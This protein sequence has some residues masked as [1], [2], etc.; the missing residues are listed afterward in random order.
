[1]ATSADFVREAS[2]ASRPLADNIIDALREAV[3]IVDVNDPKFPVVL[4]NS[5]A[6]R[7]FADGRS[8]R[9]LVQCP[10]HAL[11]GPATDSVVASGAAT[12][13]QGVSSITRVLPWR[14]P[15]GEVLL[16]TEVKMLELSPEHP[17]IMLKF[18]TRAMVS[19]S[20][21][22]PL[23]SIEYLSRDLLILDRELTITYASAGACRSAGCDSDAL[24]N[25]SALIVLPTSAIPREALTG[26]LQGKHFHDN[27]IVVLIPGSVT[28]W[29]DVDVQPIFDQSSVVGI[30]VLSLEIT[31]RRQHRRP[32]AGGD[33]RLFAL[34]EFAPEVIT[35][36]GRDG[37]LLMVSSGV[38]ESLGYAPHE[39]LSHSLL[40]HIHPEDVAAF[41]SEY[42]ALE[43]DKAAGFTRQL[44]L[45]HENGTYRWVDLICA[46]AFDNPFLRGALISVRDLTDRKLAEARVR[47]GDDVFKLAAE[48][49]NG[50]IFEWD[51]ARGGVRRFRGVDDSSGTDLGGLDSRDAWM[52]RIH[53]ED[54]AAYESKMMSAMTSGRGWTASYRIRN[55]RG[56]YRSILERGL[57]QR[58]S[59][60]D[61]IRAIGCAVDVSDISRLTVLLAE[62][63]RIAKMG[64]W[65][66]NFTSGEFEWTEEL[67]RIYEADP[68]SFAATRESMLERCT[69]ESRT[70]VKQ[71]YISA[72]RG[73]GKVDVE[74]EIIT[75]KER[76]IWVRLVAHIEKLDGRPIRAYG[77][78]QDI[79][80]QKQAQIAL[81]NRTDWLKMSM[82]MAQ[83][84][85]W[86]WDRKEDTLEFAIVDGRFVPE[87]LVVSGM[88]HLMA[89]LHSKDR[90]AVRRA[91][92][93]AF[94]KRQEVQ[95]EFR[96]K[97]RGGRHRSYVAIARPLFD[98]ANR[99][100]GLMGVTQ[101]V[102]DRRDS[103]AR[104]RRSEEL[105]R[106]TTSNIADTLI[107][108]DSALRICFINRGI[109]NI[110]VE[111]AVGQAY[112]SVLPENARTAVLDKLNRVWLTGEPETYEFEVSGPGDEIAYF[113]NRAV[114]VR[115]D[116]VKTGICITVRDITDRKRLEREILDVA[117]RE[118]QAI[119]RDL[120]D[121]L[122]QELTGV[123][124]L[125]RGLATRLERESADCVPQINEIMRLVNRSIHSAHGLARGL[126]PVSSDGGGLAGALHALA[127]H[128]RDVYGL[129]VECRVKV[130]PK[131]P[132]SEATANH[133]YRIAQEA[134][135]NTARHAH[136]TAVE[137]YLL[138]TAGKYVLRISD[139]GVGMGDAAKDGGGMG[140]KIMKYRASMIGA[141]F[142]ILSNHP[143]GTMI[144][145]SGQR[146]PAAKILEPANAT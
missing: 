72:I 125:L 134:L 39:R 20:A 43:S 35:V 100:I 65:E 63:L 42:S 97:A 109:R 104:L 79:H 59:G 98:S 81:E 113:E 33:K 75:F 135:T 78:I 107:L 121:G 96:V 44:R 18:P 83:M 88:K 146:A 4:A 103:Q 67:S 32:G 140:L 19:V 37:R 49:V 68:S 36:A 94:E 62:A 2:G 12:R 24:R 142:E 86:R 41:E 74:F 137:I 21:A 53:P 136:A 102:T 71:A 45:R 95:G 114:L 138:V 105:L 31:E 139:N 92:E 51:L 1:M 111:E 90:P 144:C 64:G 106:T 60:G 126:M 57:I 116:G 89:R 11:L 85:A 55:S 7:C 40:D 82:T 101:D 17:V 14:L 61:P 122:G 115:E 16:L 23:S 118:R 15:R 30:A 47:A 87:P 52:D 117:S 13:P 112:A 108:V 76:R 56:Q 124:L 27:S 143:H 123:A 119:G 9:S 133:L 58:N 110:S 130:S 128:S 91:I 38:E 73:D 131:R 141:T 80:A 34:T 70:L 66:Y 26:A 84:N 28:R 3:V 132:L 5:A 99:P 145:A 77:S 69:P 22:G 46:P 6:E 8:P 93:E 29:F 120:H 127:D 10:L 48:A 25:L 129:E 54:R 50:T